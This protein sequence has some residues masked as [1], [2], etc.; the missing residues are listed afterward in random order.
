M[1]VQVAQ[2]N[3]KLGEECIKYADKQVTSETY[4][5]NGAVMY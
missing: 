2:S 4:E 1:I 3:A 5:S